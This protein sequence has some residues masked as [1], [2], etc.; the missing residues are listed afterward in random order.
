MS[1]GKLAMLFFDIGFVFTL[2]AMVLGPF[3]IANW[4]LTAGV[5]ACFFAIASLVL[6]FQYWS[7]LEEE[8]RREKALKQ[9]PPR[10]DETVSK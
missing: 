3:E 4:A 5:V 7:E 6:A 10:K 1:D 9:E 2:A 8:D